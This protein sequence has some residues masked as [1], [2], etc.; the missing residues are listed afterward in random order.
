M[1]QSVF[2][3]RSS[4]KCQCPLADGISEHQR[5]R[6]Y[7]IS[8]II[9]LKL[10]DILENVYK[11]QITFW[12]REECR[13]VKDYIRQSTQDRSEFQFH[14]KIRTKSGE[15]NISNNIPSIHENTFARKFN[16]INSNTP[17]SIEVWKV[18]PFLLL[19]SAPPPLSLALACSL[20][21]LH[22][23]CICAFHSLASSLWF[24]LCFSSVD[25]PKAYKFIKNSTIIFRM[26]N[27]MISKTSNPMGCRHES[28]DVID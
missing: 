5:Q 16:F 13:L 8:T 12:C 27:C 25:I 19:L 26:E 4:Y 2:F 23:A 10:T 7:L 28:G 18:L 14:S 17:T 11:V 22:L 15:P 20:W 9:T 21:R 3:I 1:R 24:W 6:H